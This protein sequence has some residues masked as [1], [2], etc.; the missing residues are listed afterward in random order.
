MKNCFCS[1]LGFPGEEVASQLT[2]LGVV[3]TDW[4]KGEVMHCWHKWWCWSVVFAVSYYVV[5][6]LNMAASVFLLI[7]SCSPA[8]TRFHP[9]PPLFFSVFCEAQWPE[10]SRAKLP[11]SLWTR[12]PLDQLYIDCVRWHGSWVRRNVD[13][14]LWFIQMTLRKLVT[15]NKCFACWW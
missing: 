8:L 9:T 15:G 7:T 5:V 14:L 11:D 13:D 3:K 4:K 6:Q 1:F 12:V 10:E 2:E